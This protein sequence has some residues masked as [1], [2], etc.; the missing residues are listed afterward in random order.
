MGD[1]KLVV[2]TEDLARTR[3]TVSP[4]QNLIL[5]MWAHPRPS[6]AHQRWWRGVRRN[7]PYAATPLLELI[8]AHPWYVPDFLT[9]AVPGALRPGRPSVG[10]ELDALRA[11]TDAQ[12]HEDLKN[13]DSL[14]GVP[15]S[16]LELREDGTRRLS[17]VVDAARSLF[18]ACLADDW[19][20]IQ[21]RLQADIAERAVQMAY[22][23]TGRTL[24]GLHP[25]LR[26]TGDGTIAVGLGGDLQKST[27]APTIDLAGSGLVLMPSPFVTTDMIAL[28]GSASPRH[29]AVL[30]YPV[31]ARTASAPPGGRDGLELLVGRGRARALR[32]IDTGATTTELARRLGVTA[33]TASEHAAALRAAGLVDTQRNGRSVRHTLTDLGLGLLADNPE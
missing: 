4:L 28:T 24:G 3:F 10:E 2:G 30:A 27:A 9:P 6:P 29:G 11:G 21:R 1:V 8:N 18:H 16:V 12:I 17:R 32:A 13:F 15:R 26:W 14:P 7:V 31:A 25:R 22:L 33:P 23:G 19:H 5:A 20:G